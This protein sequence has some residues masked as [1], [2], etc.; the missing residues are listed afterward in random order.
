MGWNNVLHILVVSTSPLQGEKEADCGEAE[1]RKISAPVGN[2]ILVVHASSYH[3]IKRTALDRNY[4]TK[5]N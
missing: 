4:K 2:R 5:L 3:K 1:K